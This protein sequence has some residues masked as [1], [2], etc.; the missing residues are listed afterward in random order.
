MHINYRNMPQEMIWKLPY[1]KCLKG[2]QSC[3][4]A[5]SIA[6]YYQDT[7]RV[8]RMDIQLSVYIIQ[9]DMLLSN[10]SK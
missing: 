10:D 3:C 9:M 1:S 7:A 5:R 8:E 2:Y 4:V 6:L